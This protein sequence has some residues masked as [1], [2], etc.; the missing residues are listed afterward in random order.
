MSNIKDPYTVPG[1]VRGLAVMQIFTPTTPELTLSEIA[2]KLSITRS[3]A[4]RSVHTLV[5]EGY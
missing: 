4:F 3:A 5:S 1:L 2:A